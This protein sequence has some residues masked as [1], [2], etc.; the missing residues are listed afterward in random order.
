MHHNEKS[1]SYGVGIPK[2]DIGY[3]ESEEYRKK[4]D[5]ITNSKIVDRE[6]Y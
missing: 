5:G 4:F 6:I 2:V 3:I 1:G